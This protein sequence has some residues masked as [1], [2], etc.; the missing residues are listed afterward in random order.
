MIIMSLLS[1]VLIFIPGTAS[2]TQMDDDYV[3][4]LPMFWLFFMTVTLFHTGIIAKTLMEDTICMD[5]LG[6]NNI[7]KY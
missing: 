7:L 2:K 4:T 3:I 6:T 1:I 5:F